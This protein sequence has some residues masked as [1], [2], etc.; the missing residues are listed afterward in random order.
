MSKYY[1]PRQCEGEGCLRKNLVMLMIR[2]L[3]KVDQ[4]IE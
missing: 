2:E 1:F 4:H 3:V